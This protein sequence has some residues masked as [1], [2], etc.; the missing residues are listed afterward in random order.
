MKK[1]RRKGSGSVRLNGTK[2]QYVISYSCPTTGARK[3]I[4]K[5]GFTSPKEAEL[6]MKKK[7]IELEENGF[8]QQEKNKITVAQFLT[9]YLQDIEHTVSYKTFQRYKSEI[10]KVLI[11]EIGKVNLT[12]LKPTMIKAI[13]RKCIKAGKSSTT[14]RHHHAVLRKALNTALKYGF[15]DK[16]P[17]QAVELPKKEHIEMN[18]LDDIQTSKLLERI[19]EYSIYWPIML[20]V[21]TGLRVGELCGLKWKNVNLDEGYLEVKQQL[22]EE[23]GELTLVPLKTKSSKRTVYLMN[24][25]VQELKRLRIQQK[26]NRL[27]YM[28]YYR[29]QDFVIAQVD[30]SPYNPAYISRD[31]RR[32]LKEKGIC[33]ELKIPYV[34]FHD[35][36]HTHATLLLKSNINPKIVSE[37]LGHS[38]ITLTMDTYSHVLPSMQMEAMETLQKKIKLY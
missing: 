12:D 38:S 20:S 24:D 6:E 14:V 21:T 11:P 3:Q 5:S 26:K 34:R 17:C 33:S 23:N 31:Y 36:R 7:M 2:Y 30:G 9:T 4:T 19:K 35:L 29:E 22:Q 13:W 8:V 32:V 10:N 1:T 15:I 18:V 16:N 27:Q 28:E 37:R 25:T